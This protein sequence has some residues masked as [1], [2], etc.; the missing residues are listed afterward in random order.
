MDT[1]PPLNSLRAFEAA[2]R[3][4]SIRRAAEELLVTP[5]AVSRQVQRL[6]TFLGVRLFRRDPREIVLTAEGEQYLEAVSRHLD[7]I[8]EE[9]Q[10]LTGKRAKEI[11]RVRA[12]TTFSMKWLIPRLRTFSESNSSTEVRLTT[13]NEMVDFERESVDGAIRLGDGNW[14]GLE[15]DRLMRNELVP[16][17]SAA[18]AA[19]H[20]IQ[21][22]DDL[23]SVRLLHSLVRPDDWRF[24]LQAAGNQDI[25]PYA[26]DKYASSTLV[27]QATLEGQ[28]V[29]MAQ[30]ALFLDDLRMGRLV[31]PIDFSLDRG[32]FTYYFVYPR[33]RLRSPA[34]RRFREWL[35]AQADHADHAENQPLQSDRAGVPV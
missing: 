8:R 7:G 23:R 28:G 17:C 29:M 3:L 15:V 6:E 20:A 30:R 31:Q 33:N 22:P 25:D 14:P 16:L 24:W 32:D 5:G 10:K 34:F 4:Q 11:L 18:F 2:G 13:S 27:Y 19:E 12:Y 1:L 35:L 26:G 21:S 9:T